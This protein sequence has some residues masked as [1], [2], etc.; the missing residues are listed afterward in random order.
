MKNELIKISYDGENGSSDIRTLHDDE[1]ILHISLV[2]IIRTLNQENREYDESHVT[3]SMVSIIKAQLQA[4]DNDEYT[5]VPVTDG[6]YAEEQE[7]FV[8]Q[9][10]L[11][12]VMSSDRS[13]AGKKFQ[14]WL[15]HDVIP[16]LTK[17]GE[18]PAP[19]VTQD[20]EIKQLAKIVLMEIEQ[21]EEAERRNQAKF[22]EHEQK[23]EQLGNK[24]ESI[25]SGKASSD[26]ISV[27]QYCRNNLIDRTHEQ[28]I[29]GWCIKIC[30]EEGER[31]EKR[32]INGKKELFF[33]P[34]VISS[35]V[36]HAKKA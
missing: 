35:A 15:F 29:F 34:H 26:Y 18:Y 19:I 6:S 3:K 28:L 7:V 30:A 27:A 11:Y 23:L 20:S 36:S 5:M 31:S 16:T 1:G 13:Y 10:G 32:D 2:D 33:P 22:L 8:T 12:R 25:E 14:R 21:R 17:Y 4:L 24:L 9:P